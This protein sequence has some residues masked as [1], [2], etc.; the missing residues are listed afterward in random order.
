MKKTGKMRQSIFQMWVD[1]SKLDAKEDV[2]K[3]KLGKPRTGDQE[4]KK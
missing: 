3:A 1:E 2:R 4:M